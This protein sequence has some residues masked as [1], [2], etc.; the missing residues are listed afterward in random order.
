MRISLT[1][2][3]NFSQRFRALALA[4]GEAPM[5][6][7]FHSLG[8]HYLQMSASARGD[9]SPR[10]HSEFFLTHVSRAGARKSVSRRPTEA[11]ASRARTAPRCLLHANG[12]E[13]EHVPIPNH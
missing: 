2:V 6:K 9:C 13:P 5:C 11:L 8:P 1:D 7:Y 12:D 4:S 3:R 10:N